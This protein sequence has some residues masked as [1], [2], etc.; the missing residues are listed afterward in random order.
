VQLDPLS[1][2]LFRIQDA[3]GGLVEIENNTFANCSIE[4]K[5]LFSVDTEGAVELVNN[6]FEIRG[7]SILD[8]R[9][10]KINISRNLIKNSIPGS[11]FSSLFSFKGASITS[12]SQL[13]I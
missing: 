4:K 1:S 2:E 13:K 9:A 3:K 11:G 12:V 7:D 10:H 5:S 8:V 6:T